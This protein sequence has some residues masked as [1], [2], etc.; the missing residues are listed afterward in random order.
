M[1]QDFPLTAP[2][3]P[4]SLVSDKNSSKL[5]TGK[6]ISVN[7]IRKSRLP[8][9]P[10]RLTNLLDW[11]D[12][13]YNSPEEKAFWDKL[14]DWSN[15]RLSL[16]NFR[17]KRN[18]R[19]E[20]IDSNSSEGFNGYVKQKG[21][22]NRRT[23]YH[24][25]DGYAV[26]GKTWFKS[27]QKERETNYKNGVLHGPSTHW[28]ANGQKREQGNHKDDQRSGL[29][30]EWYENGQKKSEKN[31]KRFRLS[32][33]KVWLPDGEECPDSKVID[34][35]GTL[36]NY[37]LDGKETYRKNFK[38]GKAGRPIYVNPLPRELTNVTSRVEAV[39]K[40][41]QKYAEPIFRIIFR[42]ALK[43]WHQNGKK[44]LRLT[45]RTG[46]KKA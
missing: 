14:P 9:P 7:L 40:D 42:K 18:A 22:W 4:P 30:T 33:A 29:W 24:F 37:S 12:F 5:E 11:S 45:S 41:G 3:P 8:I 39:Y 1:N 10:P 16:T 31:Y 23:T 43:P 20:T 26:R 27:G 35:N 15:R 25:V 46:K 34:G 28:Y 32:Y 38:A 6:Q 13:T 44:G 19:G 17:F 21:I 2:P 36:I